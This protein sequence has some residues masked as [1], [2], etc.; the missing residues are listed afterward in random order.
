MAQ[1]TFNTTL[2][3][4]QADPLAPIRAFRRSHPYRSLAIGNLTWDYISAG[5]GKQGFMILGGGLSTGESSFDRIGKLE[6]RFHVISPSYPATQTIRRLVDGLVT[7]LDAEGIEKTHVLGHSLGAGIAHCFVRAYPDRVDKLI[8]S[9]Y[10]LYNKSSEAKGKVLIGLFRLLPYGFVTSYYKKAMTRLL[11]DAPEDTRVLMT[12][13]SF[14]LLDRQHNKK[15]LMAQFEL[16]EEMLRNPEAYRI[17][18]PVDLGSRVLILQAKDDRGFKPD[19]QAA[20]RATYPGAVVHLF[21]SGGHLAGAT[22]SE[23]YEA[24]IENHLRA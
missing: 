6:D 5:T 2:E 21:E 4:A 3:Q 14:D 12:A 22:R 13:Y 20:L 8:L 9:S 16:M 1:T 7:L 15:S 18:E 23:E 17:H 10:G 19:E 11:K 24:A